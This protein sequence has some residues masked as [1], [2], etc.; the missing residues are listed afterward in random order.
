MDYVGSYITRDGSNLTFILNTHSRSYS[1]ILSD[2]AAAKWPQSKFFVSSDEKEIYSFG[3]EVAGGHPDQTPVVVACGGDGTFRAVAT[4]VADN[5]ILGIVPMGTVN[6]VA[7][8]LGIPEDIHSAID[9]LERGKITYI[10]PGYCSWRGNKVPRLFFISV[11]MGPDANAVH[12]VSANLKARYGRVAYAASF[13][14][15]LLLQ[16]LP[17]VEYV[18]DGKKASGNGVIAVSSGCLRI[19]LHCDHSFRYKLSTHSAAL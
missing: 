4:A 8:Q 15:R 19:P 10:Y 14:A 16:P 11:S 5:A 12:Y 17:K 13:L 3:R 2:V 1:P 18:L 6:N 9:L 7:H